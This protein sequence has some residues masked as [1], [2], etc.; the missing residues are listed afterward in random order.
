[1]VVGYGF[2]LVLLM[3]CVVVGGFL[4]L[5]VLGKLFGWFGGLGFFGFVIELCGFGLLV[6]VLLLLLLVVLQVLFG[7]VVLLGWQICIVVF[8]VVVF[9]GFIVLLVL[10]KGWFWMCGGSEY[11]LMW[12][13]VLLVFVLVG[14]GVWVL[15]G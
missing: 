12:I 15:D 2:D 9:I 14:F 3:L 13:M 10:F 8:V 1:M 5:Y 7:L 11:L 6:V 4:L